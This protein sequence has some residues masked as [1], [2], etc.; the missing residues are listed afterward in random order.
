VEV[1]RSL[2]FQNCE[3]LSLISF[4]NDSQLHRIESDPFS[5]ST[6]KSIIIPRDVDFIN[7][8]AFSGI[9]WWKSNTPRAVQTSVGFISMW[10]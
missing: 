7:G 5:G 6:L 2:Y 3:S 10:L 4:E 8:S 1:L 9:G